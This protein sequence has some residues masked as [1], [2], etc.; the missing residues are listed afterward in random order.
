MILSPSFNPLFAIVSP[1]SRAYSVGEQNSGLRHL[2]KIYLKFSYVAVDDKGVDDGTNTTLRKK[3]AGN[4]N[5][6]A[7]PQNA[8]Q[9]GRRGRYSITV[10]YACCS[11]RCCLNSRAMGT[12]SFMTLKNAL[13][14]CISPARGNLSDPDGCM[15]ATMR[16]SIWKRAAASATALPKRAGHG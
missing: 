14:G 9:S 4:D 15:T 3:S 5:A 6:T 13:A 7:V 12:N 8:G 16:L 1:L 10:S 2:F 11:W